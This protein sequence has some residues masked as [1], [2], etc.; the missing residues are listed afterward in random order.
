MCLAGQQLVLVFL[1]PALTYL[2]FS[3]GWYPWVADQ[4][5]ISGQAGIEVVP[6]LVT[7]L[8]A[9]WDLTPPRAVPRAVPGCCAGGVSTPSFSSSYSSMLPSM[10]QMK[11]TLTSTLSK[12]AGEPCCLSVC[13]R[14]W[15]RW[16]LSILFWLRMSLGWAGE[17]G[18]I[19]CRAVRVPAVGG[20]S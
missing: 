20:D 2:W 6:A 16:P 3:G 8:A 15:W 14:H 7:F 12:V 11:W 1:S 4:T 17:A 9:A 5:L 19:P 10:E 13:V 18:G